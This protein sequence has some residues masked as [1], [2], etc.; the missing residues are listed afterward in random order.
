MN[1]FES[2]ADSISFE[3]TYYIP[4]QKVVQRNPSDTGH[5]NIIVHK[6]ELVYKPLR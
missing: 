1:N 4:C 6:H 5:L 3:I 2:D